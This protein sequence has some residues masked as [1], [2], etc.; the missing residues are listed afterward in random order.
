MI[1][2]TTL[3]WASDSFFRVNLLRQIDSLTLVFFEHCINTLLLA[4]VLVMYWP[5][6]KAMHKRDWFSTLI[7]GAGGS[8]VGL[9]CFTAAFSLINPSVVI[10]LQKLQPV[11]TLVTAYIF[12]N[13]RLPRGF[14]IWALVAFSGSVLISWPE[15]YKISLTADWRAA[16]GA[17]YAIL[18]GALWG[19]ATTAGRS[20]VRRYS[21]HLVT[22]L[23][24]LVGLIALSILILLFQKP[25]AESW[26]I[27]LQQPAPEAPRGVI[28][29]ILGAIIPGM[30]AM[31]IYYHGLNRVQASRA[32]FVEM[33]YPLWAV[34]LN[35]VAFNYTL[36]IWQIVGGLLLVI[37]SF[38][39]QRLP[40]H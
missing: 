12:L 40:E 14:F 33:L 35:W 16:Q 29:L 3:L 22:A 25:I 10:L 31:L 17:L 27:L 7:I 19:A 6:I 5:Q 8:A 26:Q 11:F 13:E 30:A 32:T 21:P 38:A 20:L 34:L 37:A 28:Y 1:A 18:A 4:P 24:M 36:Q 39:I 2:F 15:L 9:Y 23:R